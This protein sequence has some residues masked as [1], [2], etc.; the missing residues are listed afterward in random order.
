MAY[1]CKEKKPLPLKSSPVCVMMSQKGGASVIYKDTAFGV[2]QN[3][4][5][6]PLP[7]TGC[8]TRT[9]HIIICK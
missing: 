4:V 2:R 5:K 1:S 6:L 7:S 9:G 3:Q 8:E